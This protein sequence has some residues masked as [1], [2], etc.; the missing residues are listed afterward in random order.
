LTDF[1][2]ARRMSG[3]SIYLPMMADCERALGRPERAVALAK[4]PAVALLDDAGQVEMKIVES[5]A[6]RDLGDVAGAIRV[7]DGREIRSRS[8]AP[9]AARVRYAYADALLDD[10]QRE[11]ALEW[12]ERAAGIDSDGVTDATE[13]V[14]ELEGL[15]MVDLDPGADVAPDDSGRPAET[16]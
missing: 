8:R 3:S 2:A 9:W 10:G 12:F 7:L 11:A 1:K 4:D 15:V 6:R 14:A 5:G 13:R 16:D